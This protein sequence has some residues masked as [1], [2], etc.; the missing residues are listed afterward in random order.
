MILKCLLVS[1]NEDYFH[2][3]AN[4]QAMYTVLKEEYVALFYKLLVS[5]TITDTISTIY[6]QRN[7]LNTLKEYMINVKAN[8]D[9]LNMHAKNAREGQ[10]VRRQK[11]IT[12]P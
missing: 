8:I 6:Q 7:Q 2:K 11:L 4:E 3:I 5:K 12:S 1:L 9:F 10:K